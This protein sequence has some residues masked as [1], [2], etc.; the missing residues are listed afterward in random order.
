MLQRFVNG[1]AVCRAAAEYFVKAAREAIGERGRFSV[2]L[3]GGSTPRRLYQLLADAAIRDL[4]EWPRIDFFWGDERS[5]GPDHPDSNFHTASTELLERVPVAP[6]RVH[7]LE[8]EHADHD[9]S[10]RTYEVEM[11]KVFSIEPGQSPPIF[12][13]ILL[14]MGPDGHTASLFPHTAALEENSRWVVAN[15]VPKLETTRLTM[16]YPVL[17]RARGVLF[18][19]VGS[20]K[21]GP[22]AEIMEGPPDPKRLPAQAV[23]PESGPANWFV[24]HQAGMKLTQA[25]YP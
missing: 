12:D 15:E 21:A 13:L 25:T 17:N 6:A 10:A 1:E 7:R 14:G 24:D 2:A 20:D 23:R 4:V 5:V 18:L 11:A 16:T 8:G 19:V 9:R 3:S 22:L